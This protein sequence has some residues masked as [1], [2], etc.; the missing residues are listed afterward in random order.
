MAI[1]GGWRVF[2]CCAELLA[3]LRLLPQH[4]LA[5]LSGECP[6]WLA[7]SNRQ[8]LRCVRTARYCP[9]H[10]HDGTLSGR[11][12]G[13]CALDTQARRG[14]A[15]VGCVCRFRGRLRP[16]LQPCAAQQGGTDRRVQRHRPQGRTPNPRQIPDG[17]APC[18]ETLCHVVVGG[19]TPSPGTLEPSLSVCSKLSSATS[20][21]GL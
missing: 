14:P 20:R 16:R 19:R 17:P 10:A 6:A 8:R 11:M 21:T 13:R 18:A 5:G 4:R 2:E 12:R 7:V 15:A 9:C 3:R 1:R